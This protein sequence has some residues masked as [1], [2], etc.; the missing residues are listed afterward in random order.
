MN[1]SI[2]ISMEG[3]AVDEVVD[4]VGVLIDRLERIEEQLCEIQEMI[5]DEDNKAI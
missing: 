2:T 1:R 3:D 4:F 5:R